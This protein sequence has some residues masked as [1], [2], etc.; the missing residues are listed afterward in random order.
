[1]NLHTH[2]TPGELFALRRCPHSPHRHYVPR[3]FR[4]TASQRLQH[5]LHCHSSRG[6]GARPMPGSASGGRT[7]DQRRCLLV[8]ADTVR[9]FVPRH[10]LDPS[11]RRGLEKWVVRT[12]SSVHGSAYA[13][14]YV[15][16]NNAAISG[17]HAHAHG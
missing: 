4:H 2:L 17:A 12:V 13:G 9:H 11:G 1:M 6:V 8:R 10:V 7:R 16:T 14:T 3:I 5:R 15:S